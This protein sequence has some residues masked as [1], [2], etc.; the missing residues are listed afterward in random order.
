M[1]LKEGSGKRIEKDRRGDGTSGLTE[2]KVRSGYTSEDDE[3]DG[4]MCMQEKTPKRLQRK[5]RKKN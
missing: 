1:G 3:S 4:S 5:E 2:I